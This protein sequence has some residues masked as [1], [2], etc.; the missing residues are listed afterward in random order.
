MRSRWTNFLTT[1]GEK[2]D[3]LRDEEFIEHSLSRSELMQRWEDGWTCL[4]AAVHA[5]T[6]T[7]LLSTV[8]IRRESHTVFQAINRQSC[9]Y[10]YHIGQI[11]QLA[12]NIRGD[13]WQT[14]TVRRGGTEEF[15]RKMGI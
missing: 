14:L 9:H 1:D 2:P 11:V 10:A 3:R 8:Y 15:N 7:D 5:L 13:A 4:F 12:Q 6:G